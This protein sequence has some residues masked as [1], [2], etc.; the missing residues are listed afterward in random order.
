[1]LRE[2]TFPDPVNTYP[3]DQDHR[4]Q[5]DERQDQTLRQSR[6]PGLAPG[7]LGA[8][9]QQVGDARFQLWDEGGNASTPAVSDGY[10]Q[11]LE[12]NPLP[13]VADA[14]LVLA[15]L[16]G[17]L[18]VERGRPIVNPTGIVEFNSFS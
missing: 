18:V 16:L 2:A 9:Q 13:L 17:L 3:G 1:M 7:R 10:V 12:K 11:A 14:V 4:R 6:G 8:A 5:G 15:F